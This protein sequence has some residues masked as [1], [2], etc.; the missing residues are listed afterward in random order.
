[1]E[2]ETIVARKHIIDHMRAHKLKPYTIEIGKPLIK[3]ATDASKIYNLH[4]AKKKMEKEVTDVENRK[5]LISQ[6]MT[7]IQKRCDSLKKAIAAMENEFVLCIQQAEKKNDM[8]MVIKGNWL[9]RKSEESKGDLK[10]L[11]EQLSAL[12]EKKRKLK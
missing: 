4:L 6:D 9:K 8:S 1:M 10:I 5:L 7:E 2:E 11:E 12:E 3:A